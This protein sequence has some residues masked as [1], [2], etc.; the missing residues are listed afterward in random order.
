M[1]MVH[2][3]ILHIGFQFDQLAPFRS[4]IPSCLG[5][6]PSNLRFRF[7]FAGSS[8][9]LLVVFWHFCHTVCLMSHF[10][11]TLVGTAL[12][13]FRRP[14]LWCSRIDRL[15]SEYTF[16]I[17]LIGI[18]VGRSIIS[19]SGWGTVTSSLDVAFHPWSVSAS[20]ALQRGVLIWDMRFLLTPSSTSASS[21]FNLL[22]LDHQREALQPALNLCSSLPNG[23]QKMALFA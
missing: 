5:V 15:L 4:A 6:R 7:W 22:P 16:T 12:S 21:A 23:A 17:L 20:P 18:I 1:H 14:V 10:P 9:L 8:F 19:L 2:K 3:T 11:F 13:S